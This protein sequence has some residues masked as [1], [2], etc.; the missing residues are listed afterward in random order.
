[1]PPSACITTVEL[2]R[3]RV[4]GAEVE[5]LWFPVL[6]HHLDGLWKDRTS[7]VWYV[8]IFFNHASSY[9]SGFSRCLYVGDPVTP[10][11]ILC[12]PG[13]HCPGWQVTFVPHQHHGDIVRVLHS[14]DLLSAGTGMPKGEKRKHQA[15]GAQYFTC[16]KGSSRLFQRAP[17]TN[18]RKVT[19]KGLVTELYRMIWVGLSKST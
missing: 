9:L 12:L 2:T 6:W 18:R 7:A 13:L 14:L 11:Q 16:Q 15:E 10:G 8:D 1:M 19:S 3:T 5:S 17:H 4:R